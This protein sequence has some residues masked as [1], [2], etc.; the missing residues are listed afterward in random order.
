MPGVTVCPEHFIIL[1]IIRLNERQRLIA[2][3]LP[4]TTISRVK[5]SEAG[6]QYSRFCRDVLTFT[7]EKLL[8]TPP[9]VLYRRKLLKEGY[10]TLRGRVR[11][12]RLMSAFY[13]DMACPGS[14]GEGAIPA[15]KDDYGYLYHLLSGTFSVHPIRHLLFSFWLFG[16]GRV[17]LESDTRTDDISTEGHITKPSDINSLR[18]CDRDIADLLLTGMSLNKVSQMTGKSR[19]YLRRIAG[20][21]GIVITSRPKTITCEVKN[22][23]ISLGKAGFNR[24]VIAE[25]CGV[26]RG[27]V[28]QIFSCCIGLIERRKLCHYQSTFR[29]CKC[30]ILRYRQ[31]NSDVTRRDI[32]NA[33]NAEFFWLYYHDKYTLESILPAAIRPAGRWR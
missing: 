19:C 21:R 11:H 4:D 13:N 5:G 6:L 33:C 23:I 32:K 14:I 12:K 18:M 1:D 9:D 26:S 3:Y 27:S 29:R 20:I 24:N 22:R 17:I 30:R 16:E 25:R 8:H 31:H 10:L 28:E 2:G 7:S 15:A